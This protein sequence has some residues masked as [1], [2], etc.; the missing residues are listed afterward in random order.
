MAA[1]IG[2]NGGPIMGEAR[3]KLK[4]FQQRIETLIDEDL[5]PAK[6]AI[7]DVYAEV[8]TYG[9]D[10]KALRK[11]VALRSKDREKVIA[12]KESLELYAVA[13]GVEDLV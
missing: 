5:D 8:K 4:A 10:V 6:A 3:D 9:F 1:E 11:I 12:D 7:K 13:L 2:H